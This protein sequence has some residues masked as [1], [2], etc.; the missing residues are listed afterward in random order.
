MTKLLTKPKREQLRQIVLDCTLRRLTTAESLEYIH[1]KLKVKITERYFFII[2]K[3]I[4]D[5]SGQQLA[6]LQQNRNAYLANFFE[7]I[8]ELYKH[9]RETWEMYYK[10]KEDGDNKFQLECIK[11]LGEISVSLANLYNVVPNLGEIRFESDK[12]EEDY[13][14][15]KTQLATEMH[16][17]EYSRECKF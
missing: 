14:Y 4:V 2:K 12:N 8:A 17:G 13:D 1:Q 16:P 3:N 15:S 5:S 10:A 11:H 6:Y 7:R 9:Q